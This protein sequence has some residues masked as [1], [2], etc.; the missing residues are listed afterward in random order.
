MDKLDPDSLDHHFLALMRASD[1]EGAVSFFADH[2]R[3]AFRARDDE[4]IIHACHL[5]IASL[6]AAGPNQK[7]VDL[8]WK[9]V[10]SFPEE[11]YLRLSFA[12]FLLSFGK[13]PAQ[14]LVAADPRKSLNRGRR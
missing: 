4:T 1:Y 13:Q 2:V 6:I 12:G 11:V 10:K 14:A 5:L 9:V 7:A 8:I 3:E